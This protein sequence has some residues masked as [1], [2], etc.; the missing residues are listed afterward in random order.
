MPQYQQVSDGTITAIVGSSGGGKTAW[1][2]K[3]IADVSRLLVW[4]IE[5]QYN[6]RTKAVYTRS[7]LVKA[8]QEPNARISYQPKSLSDF[9]FWAKC[10]FAFVRLGAE[11]GQQTAIVAEELADVTSP[12]KAPEGWGMLVRRGRKYGAN[13]YG[14]TQRPAESDKTLFGNA[15]I[16]H[17]C[18]M[19]RANDRTYMARELDVPVSHILSLDRS[20]LEY[21]HK[22]MRTSSL[23]KG[24]LTF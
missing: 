22:D 15:H 10:A 16:I 9:D 4:D 1:L 11:M 12:A 2:K 21:L 7:E 5:G 13:I 17:C 14:V 23:T 20:K 6:E 19:Q 18:G 8:I 24:R 3:Q